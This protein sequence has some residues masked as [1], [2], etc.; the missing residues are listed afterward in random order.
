MLMYLPVANSYQFIK[1]DVRVWTD[2][3]A[4][5]KAAKENSP[6][7]SIDIVIA[8][9]GIAGYDPLAIAGTVPNANSLS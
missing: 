4:A 8:N 2:Q 7:K 1:C 9:A 5:F 3:L 6:C